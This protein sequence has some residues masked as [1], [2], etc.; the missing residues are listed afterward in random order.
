MAGS[1]CNQNYYF[2]DF[3]GY[4]LFNLDVFYGIAGVG[5]NFLKQEQ[6]YCENFPKHGAKLNDALI[7]KYFKEFF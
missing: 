1:A 2:I 4:F 7:D 5:D 3:V 6:C